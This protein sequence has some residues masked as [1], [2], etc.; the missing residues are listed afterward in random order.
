MI[1]FFV[2]VWSFFQVQLI[3]FSNQFPLLLLLLGTHRFDEV[4]HMENKKKK[5]IK[6][7]INTFIFFTA[8]NIGSVLLMV[9]ELELMTRFGTLETL[10]ETNYPCS[11]LVGF[12][13]NYS[14]LF[15]LIIA[16][17]IKFHYLA[18]KRCAFGE[19]FQV[20]LYF[21][22]YRLLYYMST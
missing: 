20:K 22:F 14:I 4:E 2:T 15:G 7:P 19:N 1:F 3:L 13:Y 12:N 16:H 9:L 17:I 8:Y 5:E 11:F 10:Y 6:A 18:F 21:F